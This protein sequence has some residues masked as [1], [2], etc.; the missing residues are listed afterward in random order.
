MAEK[1][2][3]R[4]PTTEGQIKKDFRSDFERVLGVDDET[5]KQKQQPP[6]E[7][8]STEPGKP[9]PDRPG[10]KTPDKAVKQTGMKGCRR[11]MASAV[12]V[13]MIGAIAA[14]L[15]TGDRALS[16]ALDEILAGGGSAPRQP[17]SP[18]G[19]TKQSSTQE[20]AKTK[21]WLIIKSD[22]ARP[23]F[24][25]ELQ[26]DG[27]TGPAVWLEPPQAAGTYKWS[28]DQL[29]VKLVLQDA[30]VGK[31][32][33][34]KGV[35]RDQHFRVQMA[36]GP[37]GVLAGTLFAEGFRYSWDKGLEPLGMTAYEATG[38]PK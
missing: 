38:E 34:G 14:Y 3:S 27:P 9:S 17:A 33:S 21:R 26:G 2:P 22:N 36:L 6:P 31:D 15:F 5:L 37:D 18:A 11:A 35:Y 32:K 10:G 30:M 13:I 20:Q 8:P 25:I 23:Q 28:G 16:G 1:K 12:I 4:P 29:Q 19:G 7:P 24:T